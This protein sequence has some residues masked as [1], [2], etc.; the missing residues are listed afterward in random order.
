MADGAA[1]DVAR[2][3][4]LC[5]TLARGSGPIQAYSELTSL[6]TILAGSCS[7]S[8]ALACSLCIAKDGGTH[9]RSILT[10]LGMRPPSWRRRHPTVELWYGYLATAVWKAHLRIMGVGGMGEIRAPRRKGQWNKVWCLD[11]L[12]LRS[13]VFLPNLEG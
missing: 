12:G 6:A 7:M 2:T 9:V 1:W 5:H 8:R 4:D 3:L 10:V 13:D 11:Q